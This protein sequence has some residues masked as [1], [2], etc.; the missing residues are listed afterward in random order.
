MTQ[1][2]MADL[3]AMERQRIEENGEE[4]E[5]ASAEEEEYQRQAEIR[6]VMAELNRF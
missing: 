2:Q 3:V 4:Y 6:F 1:E 5:S